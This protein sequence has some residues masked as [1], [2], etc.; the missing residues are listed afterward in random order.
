VRI[1]PILHATLAAAALGAAS[2][3]LAQE[4]TVSAGGTRSD[5]PAANSYGWVIT[6]SHELSPH[7]FASLSYQNEGHV[8]AHHRDGHAAQL[9]MRLPLRP[10][11]SLAGGIGPYRYFDT[12]VAENAGSYADAHGWGLISSVALLWESRDPWFYQL[13]IDRITTAG[14]LD[15]TSFMAGVGY[16]LPQDGKGYLRELSGQGTRVPHNEVAL[17]AG[18]TIV[19]SFESETSSLATMLEY[20]HAFGQYV[21]GTLAWIDEGDARLIR[22]SGIVAQVW[23]EPTFAQARY[24]LGVGVGTYIAVDEYRAERGSI[25]S[26]IVTLGASYH[27][28]NRWVA[29]FSW[30][31]IV[32]KY[33]RDTD[34]ILLGAGYR[35]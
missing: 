22:R 11:L 4:L 35:F 27:L 30:H 5:E 33:D 31:R 23:L 24:T 12:T 17:F 16:R 15:T 29:R 8:P 2:G 18:Q 19:N 21:R 14:S 9:W 10:G 6:Y 20:R 26:G 1:R 32:S 3:A 13:R 34:I 28:G 25:A 7:L